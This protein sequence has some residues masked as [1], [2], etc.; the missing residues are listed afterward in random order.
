MK[1]KF[2]KLFVLLFTVILSVS[3]FS[4]CFLIAEY[5]DEQIN[6]TDESFELLD[7]CNLTCV[8]NEEFANYDV[9]VDGTLKN[10]SEKEWESICVTLILY[11]ADGNGLGMAYGYMDYIEPYGTWR[12][13]AEGSTKYE[14]ASVKLHEIDAYRII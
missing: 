7:E 10:V 4:G 9:I 12:F 3:A 11:D 5:I 1:K 14:P 8:Y 2:L 13:C 6:N